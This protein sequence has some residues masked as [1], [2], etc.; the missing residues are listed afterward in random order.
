MYQ[1]S[2]NT[3]QLERESKQIA[4]QVAQEWRQSQRWDFTTTELAAEVARRLEVQRRTRVNG[5]QLELPFDR[6]EAQTSRETKRD[7]CQASRQQRIGLRQRIVELLEQAGPVGLTREQL[8]ESLTVKEG[9]VSAAVNYLVKTGE[10][11]QPAK[12][13]SK[14]G[15]VVAVVVLAKFMEVS[16]SAS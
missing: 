13:L 12:T 4:Y 9:S 15:Y 14:S 10:V 3:R 7:A 2:E 11:G 1:D 8:A 6:D 16:R 5:G